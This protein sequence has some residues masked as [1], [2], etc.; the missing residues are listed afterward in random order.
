MIEMSE[1]NQEMAAIITL[2]KQNYAYI[3]FLIN[4]DDDRG[5]PSIFTN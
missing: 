1:K 2:K 5:T 3:E 4:A